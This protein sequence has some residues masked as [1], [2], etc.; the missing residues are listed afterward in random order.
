MDSQKMA[1][2]LSFELSCFSPCKPFALYFLCFEALFSLIQLYMPD[3]FDKMNELDID[4]NF[5]DS[6]FQRLYVSVVPFQTV[7]RIFDWFLA[8]GPKCL[9]KVALAL[10]QKSVDKL[11]KAT[12]FYGVLQV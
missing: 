2:F 11:L 10:L 6:W 1:D 5:A 7:L 4:K 8:E 3:L 9:F 12:N